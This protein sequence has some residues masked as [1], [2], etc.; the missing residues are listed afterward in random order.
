MVKKGYMPLINMDD[1]HD[2]FLPSIYPF[3]GSP[4]AYT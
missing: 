1:A 4:Y 2:P 3:N